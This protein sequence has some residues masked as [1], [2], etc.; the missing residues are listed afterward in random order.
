MKGLGAHPLLDTA[1]LASITA[2]VRLMVGDRDT[3]VTVDETA[4]AAR[5]LPIGE[6]AVLPGTPHPLEQ[7][8]VPLLASLLTDFLNRHTIA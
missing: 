5:A 2:R 6:L 4:R 8:D 7:V 3:V 1:A